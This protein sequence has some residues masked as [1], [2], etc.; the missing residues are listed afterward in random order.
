MGPSYGSGPALRHA[1]R[2]VP[3][4]RL[5]R[6]LFPTN[7]GGGRVEVNSYHHQAVR[8]DDLAPALVANAFATSPLGEL[9]EGAETRGGRLVM[10]VQCHPE[11]RESTPPSFE[12]LFRVF[13]DASRGAAVKR[14]A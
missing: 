9:V 10:G 2:I 8:A 11:R 13:V 12:R 5:A 7:V 14:S 6:I 1:L 3:G 4:T